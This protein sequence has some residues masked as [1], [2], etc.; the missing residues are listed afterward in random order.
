MCSYFSFAQKDATEKMLEIGFHAGYD[1]PLGSGDFAKY[2]GG[3]I[4]PELSFGYEINRDY[5]VS[6]GA[7]YGMYPLTDLDR[8][9]SDKQYKLLIDAPPYSEQTGGSIRT[10]SFNTDIRKTFH[11]CPKLTPFAFIGPGFALLEKAPVDATDSTGTYEILEHYVHEKPFGVN[12]GGGIEHPLG[13]SVM[14]HFMLRY[15]MY[16]TSQVADN[17]M[18]ILAARLCLMF[19]L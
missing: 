13:S 8:Y 3:A 10:I 2:Y 9:I 1:L 5:T 6:L 11:C 16:F 19:K 7:G 12:L 4:M 15:S 18:G 17:P 14:I